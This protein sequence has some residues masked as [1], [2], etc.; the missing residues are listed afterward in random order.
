LNIVPTL[1]AVT[2]VFFHTAFVKNVARGAIFKLKIHQN[3]CAATGGKLQS[4]PDL[5][6]GFQGAA[7]WQGR[8]RRRKRRNFKGRDSVPPLFF[9]TI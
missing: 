6:A 7:S 2:A 4:S 3:A 8:G 5:L 9:F 1:L